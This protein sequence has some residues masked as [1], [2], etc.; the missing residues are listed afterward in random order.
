M[1]LDRAWV[2]WERAARMLAALQA[3]AEGTDEQAFQDRLPYVL[4][5][6]AGVRRQIG[7][8]MPKTATFE[9]W[10]ATQKT[11][12]RDA[13]TEMRH[14]QLKRLESDMKRH[15]HAQS[16]ASEGTFNGKPVNPGDTVVWWRWYFIGGH[17]DGKDVLTVL[18]TQLADLASL[19]K[20]AESRLS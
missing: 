18:S 5:L 11:Q 17:F 15:L 19:I 7:E 10:W 13:I 4:D 6:L 14:A 20:E 12:D 3:H 8:Y 2:G 16:W 9:S 1:R